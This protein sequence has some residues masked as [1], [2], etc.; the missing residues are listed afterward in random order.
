MG[1]PSTASALAPEEDGD[2]G[3]GA[4][5]EPGVAAVEQ[6]PA[7]PAPETVVPPSPIAAHDHDPAG[8]AP[9]SARREA[10]RQ[11]V[12]DAAREVFA[13]MGVIGGTVEDIC[14]RAGFTRG[15]FYSNFADKDD[16]VDALVERE[17]T[18]LLE[19]LD[20]AFPEVDREVA[21]AEDLAA[22]LGGI[23]HRILGSMP[24]DRQLSLIQTELEIFAIRRPD[25]AGRFVEINN[26]F[27][28]RIARLVE[29]A[30]HR[31][32]R[33]LLVDASIVTD[34]IVAI[35][36]RSVRRALLAGDGADPDAMASAVLPGLL[37]AFSRPVRA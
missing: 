17:H 8:D 24:I 3:P 21:E 20:A 18:R 1:S 6:P 7:T 32:G 23:V 33:E 10:T 11:R 5:P 26:R 12:L 14:E 29:E 30:M 2:A 35:A 37:L 19:H 28:E 16:V 34:S 25:Q 27:R 4:D 36:E 22:A 9:R 31:Y 13:E 15:A